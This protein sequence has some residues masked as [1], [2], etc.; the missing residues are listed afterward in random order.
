MVSR[1]GICRKVGCRSTV[2]AYDLTGQITC[3]IRSK[4]SDNMRNVVRFAK[5]SQGMSGAIAR[6]S[7]AVTDTVCSDANLTEAQKQ[8]A[9]DLVGDPRCPLVI[10]L[11]QPG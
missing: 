10:A 8:E 7:A 5:N 9:A 11:W 6:Q 1:I 3:F 2:G 4:E